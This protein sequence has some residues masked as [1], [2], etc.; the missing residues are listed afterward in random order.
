MHI[1]SPSLLYLYTGEALMRRKNADRI[2][3]RKAYRSALLLFET[4]GFI[5]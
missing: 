3:H 1:A 4:L 5:G 2:M